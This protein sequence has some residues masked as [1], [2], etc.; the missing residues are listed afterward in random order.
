MQLKW[1]L[2]A[3]CWEFRNL[4]WIQRM[5]LFFSLLYLAFIHFAC[6]YSR[7]TKGIKLN[8]GGRRTS[9]LMVISV[10]CW[11]WLLPTYCCTFSQPLRSN[12]VDYV[13]GISRRCKAEVCHLFMNNWS[14]WQKDLHSLSDLGQ[15]ACWA[16]K[17]AGECIKIAQFIL[18][19]YRLHTW[20]MQL[21]SLSTIVNQ[22]SNSYLY[23]L[24][25]CLLPCALA[26][27]AETAP[28]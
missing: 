4:C 22:L 10:N 2:R 24:S 17:K 9:D 3:P 15:L 6:S 23:R 16:F 12:H 7:K 20:L 25:L 21:L 27:T 26:Y 28:K 1:K 18:Y 5:Q 19:C 8:R 11:L 14:D 13:S